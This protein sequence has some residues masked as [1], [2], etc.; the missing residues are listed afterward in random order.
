LFL[1]A[2]LA[3]VVDPAVHAPMA[4]RPECCFAHGGGAP[5]LCKMGV[6]CPKLLRAAS[7]I[8]CVT[9]VSIIKSADGTEQILL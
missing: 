2:A 4:R 6:L 3:V 9:C 8:M 1:F 5:L 7:L